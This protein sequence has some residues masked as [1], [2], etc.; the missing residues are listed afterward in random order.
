MLT[1]SRTTYTAKA[2][3]LHNALE[4]ATFRSS[5]GIQKVTF[6][7]DV[8][9]TNFSAEFNE[10][11]VL[12][13]EITKF[14]DV[15]LRGGVGFFEMSQRC[16]GCI[17]LFAFAECKLHSTITVCLFIFHLCNNTWPCLNYCAGNVFTL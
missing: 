4:T 6:Y 3:T 8:R 7:E 15:F 2:V 12:R 16:L 17:F 11:V 13:F 5:Y 9:D 14:N 1:V 10:T